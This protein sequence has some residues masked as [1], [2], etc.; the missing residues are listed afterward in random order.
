MKSRRITTNVKYN[1]Q[2]ISDNIDPYITD[3]SFTDNLSGQADDVTINLGDRER[4]WMNKWAPKKGASLEISL[5]VSADWPSTN[6][7]SRKLGYFEIDQIGTNGPPNKVSVQAQSVPQNSSLKGT[8]KS[9]TWENTNLKKVVRDISSKNKIN[10]YY[11][12][13]DNPTYDSLSQDNETDLTF[14]H[15]I[16]SD[17]GLSLKIANKTITI[18]D[19]VKLE[20]A[21]S[22]M[23]IK[24]TDPRMKNYSGNDSLSKMYKACKV[25][26]TNPTTKKTLTYTF[27]PSKPPKTD[28]ILIVNEEVTSLSQA[29]QLAKKKLREENKEA[30]T[31]S[32]K[33]AGFLNLYAGQTVTLS[34]FGSFDGKYIITSFGATV[35]NS[36]ETSLE[37][38]KCLEGY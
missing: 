31:F 9:R 18:L 3:I 20:A 37:L 14:L 6:Q 33:I 29:K 15:R 23:T 10:F 24:R 21:A 32:L 35:G 34:D 22:V 13:Q 12:A 11:Y 38:R 28:R 2:S 8:P 27:T 36:S 25:T 4:K 26:Y 30:T 1:N 16:C 5:T 17:A 7:I 19:D